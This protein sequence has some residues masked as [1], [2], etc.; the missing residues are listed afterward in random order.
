M[1]MCIHWCQTRCFAPDRLYPPYQVWGLPHANWLAT[2]QFVMPRSYLKSCQV[3][4]KHVPEL[5]QTPKVS[6]LELEARLSL[7]CQDRKII[8]AGFLGV[9]IIHTW[10]CLKYGMPPN[11][12]ILILIFIGMPWSSTMGFRGTIYGFQTGAVSDTDFFQVPNKCGVAGNAYAREHRVAKTTLCGKIPS[13]SVLASTTLT[14]SKSVVS[15]LNTHNQTSTRH[16][17]LHERWEWKLNNWFAVGILGRSQQR[18][19][20]HGKQLR[21]A[22]CL[23]PFVNGFLLPAIAT[24]SRVRFYLTRGYTATLCHIYRLYTLY[25]V[26]LGVSHNYTPW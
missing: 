14:C 2:S 8:M 22:A 23:M 17:W 9:N 15:P 6:H 5:L 4:A 3:V 18:F 19:D 26:Q 16:P 12:Y 1:T 7:N 24:N 21:D 10:L 11:G 13:F 20:S 25:R